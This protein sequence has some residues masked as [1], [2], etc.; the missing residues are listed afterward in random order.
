MKFT[1]REMIATSISAGCAL[2]LPA[3]VEAS[4][5]EVSLAKDWLKPSNYSLMI[6]TKA[7]PSSY[8]AFY[9]NE[10]FSEEVRSK[11]ME[12]FAKTPI[13]VSSF[14]PYPSMPNINLPSK[15][16]Y[17]SWFSPTNTFNLFVSGNT[18][19]DVRLRGHCY[20]HDNVE[21]DLKHKKI[22]AKFIK[23]NFGRIK[24]NLSYFRY[25]YVIGEGV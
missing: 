25:Q 8:I 10:E 12:S 9:Q 24:E 15:L 11:L 3:V 20:F 23:V 19:F 6:S 14:V 16:M 4:R 21:I 18:D 17:A 2:A 13:F 5:P 1:R 7:L 22:T